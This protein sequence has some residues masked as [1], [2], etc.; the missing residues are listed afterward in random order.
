M[1]KQFKQKI[2]FLVVSLL[3]TISSYAED[4]FNDDVIDPAPVPIDNW[5]P[6][7]VIIA[8]GLVFYYTSKR[9]ASTN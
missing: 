6:F 4:P 9:K 3:L 5:I 7:I 2:Y 1:K 8:I